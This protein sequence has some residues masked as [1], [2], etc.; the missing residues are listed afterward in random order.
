MYS[1]WFRVPHTGKTMEVK[2]ENSLSQAQEI[3]DLLSKNFHM[4]N[5]RP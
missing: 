1:I 5:T 4:V 3:W 2:I